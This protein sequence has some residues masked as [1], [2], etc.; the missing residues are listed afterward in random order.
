MPLM[1]GITCTKEIRK[2]EENEDPR[3][4]I[5][6]IAMTANLLQD[7][8]V[9]CKEAGFSDFLSKPTRKADLIAIVKK[10][11]C[12]ESKKLRL[13]S[14]SDPPVFLHNQK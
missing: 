8:P 10:W 5:P 7:T 14:L 6:V 12:C 9:V 13:R 2:M 1:D 4:F 3:D 11:T